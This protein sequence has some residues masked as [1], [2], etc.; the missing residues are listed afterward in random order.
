MAFQYEYIIIGVAYVNLFPGNPIIERDMTKIDD[1]T[2]MYQDF[3][4]HI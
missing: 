1:T 3:F 2:Y 4:L